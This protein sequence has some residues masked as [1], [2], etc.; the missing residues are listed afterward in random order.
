MI[1]SS[2]G[3]ILSDVTIG[4]YMIIDAQESVS[5][6]GVIMQGRGD[7]CCSVQQYVTQVKLEYRTESDTNFTEIP[8]T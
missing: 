2:T 8:S 5:I 6:S 4:D 1:D 7:T 3:W